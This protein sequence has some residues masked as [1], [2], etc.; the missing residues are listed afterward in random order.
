LIEGP[1][2]GADALSATIPLVARPAG[3]S[4][5]LRVV[6]TPRVLQSICAHNGGHLAADLEA[7]EKTLFDLAT[8]VAS[9][10]E[11]AASLRGHHYAVGSATATA[12]SAKLDHAPVTMTYDFGPAGNGVHIE[13]RPLP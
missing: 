9:A 1:A 10:V 2:P 3:P 8:R 13:A 11:T 7:L 6:A 5:E 12:A 4:L